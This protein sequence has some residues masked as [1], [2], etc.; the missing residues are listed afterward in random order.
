M[1]HNLNPILTKEQKRIYTKYLKDKQALV[2]E[3]KSKAFAGLTEV[4]GTAWFKAL[5]MAYNVS[6]APLH[7]KALDIVNA[8]D[9]MSINTANAILLQDPEVY[10]AVAGQATFVSMRKLAGTKWIDPSNVL[11]AVR[12][13]HGKQLVRAVERK[14][15][16][17]KYAKSLNATLKKSPS[18]VTY[19]NKVMKNVSR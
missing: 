13:A 15:L 7:Q 3:I 1:I 2:K 11:F 10:D 5:R 12:D 18:F 4:L 14:A 17:A 16:P 19:Y 6:R 8:V 9:K